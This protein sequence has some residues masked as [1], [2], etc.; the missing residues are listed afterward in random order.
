MA[1]CRPMKSA[2]AKPAQ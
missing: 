2:Q 1:I